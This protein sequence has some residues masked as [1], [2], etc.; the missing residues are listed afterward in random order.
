[1]RCIWATSKRGFE[2]EAERILPVGNAEI[3]F[4]F[5]L[6]TICYQDDPAQGFLLQRCVVNG[7]NTRPI[8]LL[9]T[10]EERLLGIQL[11]GPGLKCL[12]DIPVEEFRDKVFDGFDVSCCLQPLYDRLAG[13]PSFALQVAEVMKWIRNSLHSKKVSLERCR[14]LTLTGSYAKNA[15]LSVARLRSACNVTDRH[16]RRLTREF[17]GLNAIDWIAYQKYLGT[18]HEIHTDRRP[19]TDISYQNGYCDQ[20]HFIREF[21]SF[22]G[23]TPGQYRTKKSG[24]VGHLYS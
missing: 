21:K 8:H 3:L 18:L 22:T 14:L 6:R 1:M 11:T 13:L 23:L 2:S 24:L 9:K 7:L 12:F 10:K 16:L 15:P 19:L 20:S 17:S 5:T 4:N